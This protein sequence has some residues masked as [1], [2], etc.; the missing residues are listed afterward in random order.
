MPAATLTTG[1]IARHCRVNYRTVLR[2]IK[3]GRLPAYQLP[4]RGDH[5]VE[6]ADFRRFLVDNGL[7]VPV[8]IARP[9]NRVLIVD[10]DPAMAASLSRVLRRAGYET[11]VAGNGFQA[12][13][14]LNDFKPQ[15]VTLD[16]Q[17]PGIDGH[18]VLRFIRTHPEHRHLSVLIV[19][20][21]SR[22]EIQDAVNAGA[23]RGMQKPFENQTLL[24]HV[25]QLMGDAAA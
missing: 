19:S 11:Q 13:A 1:Q 3:A 24:T 4:G 7:P 18:E 23:T 10:D 9:S 17:M 5:R 2:W 22:S 8:E 21:Q 20:A 12:G 25:K 6:I 16:L 15:L 14:V